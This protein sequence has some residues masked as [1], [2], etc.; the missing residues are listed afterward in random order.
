MPALRISPCLNLNCRSL[1]LREA[2]T[3]APDH[4]LKCGCSLARPT[5]AGPGAAERLRE[6]A[7]NEAWL[8][9]YERGR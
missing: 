8:D 7:E 5:F 1:N 9:G 2:D 4:C 3:P 6:Y